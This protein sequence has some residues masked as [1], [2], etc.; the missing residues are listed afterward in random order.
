[1][2]YALCFMLMLYPM[3]LYSVVA[4]SYGLILWKACFMVIYVI[5]VLFQ[6]ISYRSN[7]SLITQMTE[8]LFKTY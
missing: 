8:L 5:A 6:L 3:L 4:Y 7:K 1:M 2:L